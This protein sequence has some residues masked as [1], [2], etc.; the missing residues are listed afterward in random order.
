MLIFR[1]CQEVILQSFSFGGILS[2]LTSAY[3][4]PYSFVSRICFSLIVG[5]FS[6]HTSCLISERRLLCHHVRLNAGRRT[7]SRHFQ[8]IFTRT[9]L[10]V[11]SSNQFHVFHFTT[12]HWLDALDYNP[13][14]VLREMFGSKRLD[15]F[16]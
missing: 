13:L 12:F 5:T 4:I 8:L 1:H 11:D 16:F 14:K 3:P 10:A 6:C 7:H 2:Y 15:S 9:Y